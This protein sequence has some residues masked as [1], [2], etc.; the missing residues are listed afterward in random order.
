MRTSS[1]SSATKFGRRDSPPQR[2]ASGRRPRMCARNS[3]RM[4]RRTIVRRRTTTT[5]RRR[6]WSATLSQTST[7]HTSPCRRS[8]STR[9]RRAQRLAPLPN[10]AAAA[11]NDGAPDRRGALRLPHGHSR[12]GRR[13]R[14]HVR[15]RLSYS[16]RPHR[17][18]AAHYI[19]VQGRAHAGAAAAARPAPCS[20]REAPRATTRSAHFE[21]DQNDQAQAVIAAS[22]C[23]QRWYHSA[24]NT[25]VLAHGK[26]LRD[27]FFLP[28]PHAFFF[29]FYAHLAFLLHHHHGHRHDA[30]LPL[31]RARQQRLGPDHCLSCTY[32]A[33]HT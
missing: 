13:A 28:P 27:Q 4:A 19:H 2:H 33:P 22:P 1:T 8:S 20:G 9:T 31:Q 5:T 6:R 15:S 30:L 24:T 23:V 16:R 14:S 25:D 29:F 17:A 18:R 21:K 12:A 7:A 3:S 26:C 10:A 11:Q 32:A